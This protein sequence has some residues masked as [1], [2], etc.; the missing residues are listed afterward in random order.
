MEVADETHKEDQQKTPAQ[1]ANRERQTTHIAHAPRGENHDPAASWPPL[2]RV[3]GQDRGIPGTVYL[4]AG[5]PLSYHPLSGPDEPASAHFAGFYHQR[6]VL[7]E[8]GTRR[9]AHTKAL[10]GNQKRTATLKSKACGLK[11]CEIRSPVNVLIRALFA[12]QNAL[13]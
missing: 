10:A 8:P 5:Q 3:Q 12:W 9:S 11:T 1:E 4:Q 6:R 7:Q 2:W 13:G